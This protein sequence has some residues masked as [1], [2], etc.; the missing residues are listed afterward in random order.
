MSLLPLSQ[1]TVCKADPINDTVVLDGL[2]IY[3]L[4]RTRVFLLLAIDLDFDLA[5]V[6]LIALMSCGAIGEPRPVHA[7][8]PV[9]ATKLP[10]FPCTMSRKAALP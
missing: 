9:L 2:L 6:G 7:S 4:V 5:E 3:F 1:R 8:Q 10:L